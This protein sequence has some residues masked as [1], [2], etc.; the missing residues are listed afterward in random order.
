MPRNA[1]APA[2][3]AS[4]A[5]MTISWYIGVRWTRASQPVRTVRRSAFVIGPW[6]ATRGTGGDVPADLV[7]GD[8]T[9][10]VQVVEVRQEPADPLTRV[11]DHD[12]DGQVVTEAE[13]VRGVNDRVRAEPLDPPEHAGAGKPSL[14]RPMDDLA[15]QGT[16][17]PGVALPDHHREAQQVFSHWRAPSSRH[18]RVFARRRRVARRS[19]K[20]RV[21]VGGVRY[22]PGVDGYSTRELVRGDA[23]SV[24]GI[25]CARR[26]EDQH[27]ALSI[28]Y[29][30]RGSLT[31]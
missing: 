7:E 18:H 11:H 8:Q 26:V 6:S 28:S 3:P 16:T 12:Q 17:V 27:V 2:R 25:R 24:F 29:M 23:L 30:R 14:V 15:V 19:R 4:R 31:Y 1:V 13:E 9:V 21:L 5:L 10:D 22:G 20:V